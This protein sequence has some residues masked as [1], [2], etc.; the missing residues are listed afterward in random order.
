VHCPIFDDSAYRCDSICRQQGTS[1]QF[2][3]S[4]GGNTEF[5]LE[6]NRLEVGVLYDVVVI[7][8]NSIGEGPPSEASEF[9]RVGRK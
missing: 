9:M 6:N 8:V 3:L 5:D 4:A 2:D 1:N 7:A